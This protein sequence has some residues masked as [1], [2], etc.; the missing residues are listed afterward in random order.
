[1]ALKFHT[2]FVGTLLHLAVLGGSL[3]IVKYLVQNRADVRLY[4]YGY[5][6]AQPIERA[7]TYM[8]GTDP[9]MNSIFCYLFQYYAPYDTRWLNEMLLKASKYG[10][11]EIC[12]IL[13][14]H[15]AVVNYQYNQQGA[16]LHKAALCGHVTT[17]QSLILAGAQINLRDNS[18]HTPLYNAIYSKSRDTLQIVRILIQSGAE[19]FQTGSGN[20][21]I[22]YQLLNIVDTRE[23][24]ELRLKLRDYF[25]NILGNVPTLQHI[26]RMCIRQNINNSHFK[27]RVNALPLPEKLKGYILYDDCPLL[28]DD[29]LKSNVIL[30]L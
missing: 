30:S 13:I 27:P 1:M 19:I 4:D 7:I 17:V 23:T 25:W 8:G 15:G 22:M 14:Q 21:E 12:D 11:A 16:A 24:F 9:K 10:R 6:S 3:N 2:D 29:M 26:S 18:G 5:R 28:S 20:N